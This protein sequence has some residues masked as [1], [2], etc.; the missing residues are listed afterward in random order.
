MAA[1]LE[2]VRMLQQTLQ[3]KS[4]YLDGARPQP[5]FC[6]K[7][8]FTC[9]CHHGAD[10]VTS[11]GDLVDTL[12]GYGV[13]RENVRMNTGVDRFAFKSIQIQVL[14]SPA[15][16]TCL[17]QCVSTLYTLTPFEMCLQFLPEEY[18]PPRDAFLNLVGKQM[19]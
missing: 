4:I 16:S 13:R 5:I 10:A 11:E 8:Q 14:A 2:Q 9:L 17:R 15:R 1:T 7:N 18:K 3:R 19:T 12:R 6:L